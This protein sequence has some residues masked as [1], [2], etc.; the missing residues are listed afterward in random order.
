MI[1]D[2]AF[3]N[4]RPDYLLITKHVVPA[5]LREGV[6]RAQIEEL[7]IANPR[8]FYT[9]DSSVDDARVPD[10]GAAKTA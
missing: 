5:L 4:E 6:T 3:A 2:P 9:R 7:M 10:R 1:G 8:Q